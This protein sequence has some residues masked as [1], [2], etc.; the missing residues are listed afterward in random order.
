MSTAVIIVNYRTYESLGRCLASLVPHL[1]SDDEV[2]VVDYHSDASALDKAVD[3]CAAVLKL[4]R[5]DNLGFAAGVNLAAARTRADFLLLLNPD[6]T[7]EGPAVRVLADWLTSHPGFA[8]V[9]PRVLN[10]D[11]TIQATA[12]RFPDATTLLGGRSTWLTARF[13]KNWFSRHNLVGLDAVEPVQV[14]WLSGACFMTR[15]DVF[16]MID[17]FDESFFLYWEDADYCRRTTAAGFRCAYVPTVSIRH[18]GGASAEYDLAGAIGAFHRSAFRFYWKHAS[19]VARLAA[20]LVRVGLWLRGAQ[21]LR[22]EL[23]RR[24]AL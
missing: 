14:D 21:R 13:P 15:R 17:G 8:V 4:P 18:L 16:N 11:G 6:T 23:R 20:P 22:R 3:R 10:V 5:R 9:G 12:R 2:I 24:R 19:P 1:G 7:V